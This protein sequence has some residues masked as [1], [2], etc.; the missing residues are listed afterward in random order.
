MFFFQL[1]I[2]IEICDDKFLLIDILLAM[3]F[4]TINLQVVMSVN[5]YWAV[6]HPL[7]YYVHKNSGYKKR[8][9]AFCVTLGIL[10]VGSQLV[11]H[12]VFHILFSL[13]VLMATTAIVTCYVFILKSLSLRVRYQIFANRVLSLHN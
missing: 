9:I 8:T 3:F 10:E 4:I 12:K 7:S 2:I 6:C 11:N 1:F 13:W 5:R